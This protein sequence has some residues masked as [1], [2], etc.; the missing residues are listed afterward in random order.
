MCAENVTW[1][2]RSV[3]CCTCSKSVHLR[4]SQL[5]FSRFRTL[6]SSQ[7]W[8]CHPCFFWR[9]HTYLHCDFILGL[10]QLVYFHCST[11]PIWPPL[12]MQ[13]SHP[14]LTFNSLIF[15]SPT[16]YSLP[17]RPRHPLMFAMF[18]ISCF[19]FT[20]SLAQDSSMKC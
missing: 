14:I 7:F 13:H 20:P 3:K 12:L 2:G 19:L 9:F 6:G 1:R 11:W 10:L 8:T 4:C 15:L 16:L 5:S 18:Y 17:L